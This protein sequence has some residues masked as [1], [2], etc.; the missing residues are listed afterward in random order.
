M[1]SIH[2]PSISRRI[3]DKSLEMVAAGPGW[4]IAPEC[5][6]RVG[7]RGVTFRAISGVTAKVEIGFSILSGNAGPKLSLARKIWIEAGRSAG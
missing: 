2:G 6:R 7:Q 5:A 4:T 1:A 3:I